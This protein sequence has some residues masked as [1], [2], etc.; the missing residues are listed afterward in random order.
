MIT[1]R[2]ILEFVIGILGF[3]LILHATNWMAAAGVFLMLLANNIVHS[4]RV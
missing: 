1:Q 2:A 3:A 4:S